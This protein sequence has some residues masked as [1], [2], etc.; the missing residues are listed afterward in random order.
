ML[1]SCILVIVSVLR[2]ADVTDPDAASS[3]ASL[4]IILLPYIPFS[5]STL[6][7]VVASKSASSLTA[8]LTSPDASQLPTD[9]L[10]SVVKSLSH[11]AL[12]LDPT[13]VW[14]AV[15]VPLEAL[16]SWF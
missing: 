6:Q 12:L 9:T 8:F 13:V 2:A 1:T 7:P 15:V 5:L 11:L 4:L 16:H 14:D 3:L 10:R